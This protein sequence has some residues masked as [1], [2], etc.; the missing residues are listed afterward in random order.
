MRPD[1]NT[2]KL[3]KKLSKESENI[4]IGPERADLAFLALVLQTCANSHKRTCAELGN[5]KAAL[6]N[7]THDDPTVLELIERIICMP[8]GQD[9]YAAAGQLYNAAVKG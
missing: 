6:M 5:A 4:P 1:N 8:L 7:A 9:L 2:R 3:L